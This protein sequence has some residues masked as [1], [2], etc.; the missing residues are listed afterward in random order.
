MCRAPKPN[1]LYIPRNG[2]AYVRGELPMKVI[3]REVGDLAQGVHRQ[4]TF[5]MA[6]DVGEHGFEPSGVGGAGLYVSQ[7][8]ESLEVR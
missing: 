7:R 4:V 2:N 5:E 6:V 1:Q 3:R 8:T